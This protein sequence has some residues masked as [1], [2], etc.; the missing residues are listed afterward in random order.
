MK[1][2]NFTLTLV[3]FIGNPAYYDATIKAVDHCTSL[4]EFD[5]IKIFTCVHKQHKDAESIYIPEVNKTQYNLFF[6]EELNKYIDTEFCLTVQHDG[7]IIDPSRWNVNFT[8]YDYIGAPWTD[9]KEKNCVGNGGFSLRSKKF[10]QASSKLIYNPNIKFQPNI[11]GG[12]LATTEDWFLCVHNYD[13]MLKQ[14][15]KFANKILASQFSIEHPLDTKPFNR[16]DLST[17]RSFGF[18]GEFNTAAMSLIH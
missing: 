13:Y 9:N 15:I 1:L 10:L 3:T 4:I 18:H 14:H 16:N 12:T 11:P 5:K 6:V 8:K 2:D 17:Y 7:F